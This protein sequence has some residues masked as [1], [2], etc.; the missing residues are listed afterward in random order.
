MSIF[1]DTFSTTTCRAIAAGARTVD[2]R[3]SSRL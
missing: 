1:L 2:R 3:A